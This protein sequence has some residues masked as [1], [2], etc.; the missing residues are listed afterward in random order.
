M[1]QEQPGRQTHLPMGTSQPPSALQYI[2]GASNS[3][4][5]LTQ[6]PRTS[7]SAES[8]PVTVSG[9]R[10]RLSTTF[11]M[12]YYESNNANLWFIKE[13]QYVKIDTIAADE[14][15]TQPGRQTHL[16]MGTSQPPS[17]LQYILGASNSSEALTQPPR[18]S[19]SA[20]SPP[21]TVSGKRARLS[22]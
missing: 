8:P 21:V 5:A 19:T 18:T 15:F 12:Y 10:A 20:E 13:S 7:T 4:E 6:P 22:T 3:S 9:K 14:S 1:A 2:L 16:P 17:A 11:N